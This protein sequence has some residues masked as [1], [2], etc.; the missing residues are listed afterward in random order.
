M[1]CTYN[2]N[3][4]Y[5]SDLINKNIIFYFETTTTKTTNKQGYVLVHNILIEIKLKC[6]SFTFKDYD[7]P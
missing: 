1:F 6:F 5:V 2:S 7:I 4:F 3:N